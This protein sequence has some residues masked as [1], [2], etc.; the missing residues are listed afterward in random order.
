[1]N[2][3]VAGY[4]FFLVMAVLIFGS[5]YWAYRR[6]T[7]KSVDDFV[8]GGRR[9]G[10]GIISASIMASWIWTTTLI[11]ASEAGMWF[12][13]SGGFHYAWGAIVPFLVFIPVALRLRRLMP[14]ASTFAEFIRER[15]GTGVHVLFL[16]FGI[17]V[18]F[19]VYTEQLVGAGILFKTTFGVDYKVAVVMTTALVVSY[20]ALGGFRG[21]IVTDLFQFAVVA[22]ACVFL[23]P[24]LLAK[25]GG[26]EFLYQGLERVASDPKD[27]NHNAEAMDWF[28][29]SGLRY[30]LA[31]VVIA[32]GQVLLEQGYYQRAVAAIDQKR[33]RWAYI[34][35]GIVAWFPIPLMFGLVVGGTG[36]AMGFGAGAELESTSDVA[37]YVMSNVLGPVAGILFSVMVFMAATS[38]ADT[39]LAGA[40]SLFTVDVYERYW[41]KGKPNER[42]QLRFGR[43]V[44]IVYGF[45]G[46]AVALGLEGQSLLQIDIF[47]GILFAAPVAALVFGLF[48]RRASPEAAVISIAAGLGGGLIA[49]FSI[50]DEDINWFVGNAISLGAP[51]ILMV[52]LP[53]LRKEQF[54]FGRLLNWK[55]HHRAVGG[56]EAPATAGE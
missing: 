51:I 35:G 17:G 29:S 52:V 22:I 10:L 3:P 31:A 13:A 11:G 20:V 40:Q 6:H 25:V 49:W 14:K 16:V 7:V 45:A 8:T 47:S 56:Q 42:L 36:L 55:P 32:T 21:S 9:M 19:Y 27:P 37:P 50:P 53:L 12:G 4:V 41:N 39:S 38:T 24:W 26:A 2:N 23:I 33:L 46:M 43:V 44:T 15:Y 1:M 30:G 54:E 48:W 28:S 5:A 34:I 18:G